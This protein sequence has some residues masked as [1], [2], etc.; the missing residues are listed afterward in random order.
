VLETPPTGSDSQVMQ[1]HGFS[2]D[3]PSLG[4]RQH[5]SPGLQK[6]WG[7][8][9][10][11]WIGDSQK[12]LVDDTWSPDT[13]SA[14]STPAAIELAGPRRQIFF[15]PAKTNL[16]IVTCGGLCPGLNDV[17]RNLV[18]HGHYGYGVRRIVGLRYGFESLNPQFGHRTLE[19]TPRGVDKIHHGGG[20]ILG[21]SR[22]KQDP[23]IMAESLRSLGIDV[24]FVVGGDGS[25]KAALLLHQEIRKRGWPISIVGIPK[26]IDND[27]LFMDQSF[28]YLTACAEALR[29]LNVAH[30]EARGARNG[31]GL[32]KLMG[33]D[34]GFIA[35]SAALASGEVNF[36]LIPEVPFA[37]AG[38][39]GLLRSVERRVLERGH[40]VIAVAEGAGQEWVTHGSPERDA[41]GNVRYGDIGTFLREKLIAH[42][43]ERGLEVNLKYIDPSYELRG[44][45]AT[46]EDRIFCLQLAR[47]AIHAGMSGKT[48][49]VVARWHQRFVHLPMAVVAAGRRKVDREGDLWRCV[50]ESTGQPAC[51]D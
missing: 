32:V 51:F 21:T 50:L 46:A 6:E 27:L 7:C 11:H 5:P 26:T 19:L 47:H 38:E 30:S 10:G 12:I 17:I 34:S 16:A 18:M 37:L 43:R 25:Q 14:V 44:G 1:S 45:V 9:D 36:V 49:L 41:S 33:R 40:A 28:G 48:G 20:S 42:F 31:I 35:C 2:F 22:G 39:R 4:S 24:L 23:A 29:T 8:S 13:P 3:I 15:D